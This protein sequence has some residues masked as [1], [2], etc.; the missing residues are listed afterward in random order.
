MAPPLG[1]LTKKETSLAQ[2][3]A[4]QPREEVRNFLDML[5][6]NLE[7]NEIT[8]GWSNGNPQQDALRQLMLTPTE[9]LA[10]INGY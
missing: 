7:P 9:V 2:D 5:Y 10:R 8:V 3:E 6:P 4:Q 1:G